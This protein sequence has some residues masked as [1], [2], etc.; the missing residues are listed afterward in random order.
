MHRG[1]KK[2]QHPFVIAIAS[3]ITAGRTIN[4]ILAG[5]WTSTGLWEK[6]GIN[7]IDAEQLPWQMYEDIQTIMTL[8]ARDQEAQIKKAQK[9]QQRR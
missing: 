6:L 1:K 8:E 4:P 7:A 5:Y 2:T 9:Q 3:D